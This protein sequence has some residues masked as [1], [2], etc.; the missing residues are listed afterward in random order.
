MVQRLRRRHLKLTSNARSHAVTVVAIQSFISIVFC[1]A[2]A[3][4]KSSSRLI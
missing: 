3:N 1:V 2:K 4:T